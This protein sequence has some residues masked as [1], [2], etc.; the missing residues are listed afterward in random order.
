MLCRQIGGLATSKGSTDN[1]TITVIEFGWVSPQEVQSMS[2]PGR[3]QDSEFGRTGGAGGSD[4]F[5]RAAADGFGRTS[6]GG[7]GFGRTSGGGDE[8]D[9]GDPP[10][11]P[12]HF[13]RHAPLGLDSLVEEVLNPTL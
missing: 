1:L 4:G 6:G 12:G 3:G 8:G 9:S 10:A 7:D 11:A 2:A 5:G 13:S